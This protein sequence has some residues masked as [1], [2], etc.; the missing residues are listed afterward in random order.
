MLNG[1]ALGSLNDGCLTRWHEVASRDPPPTQLATEYKTRQLISRQQQ[2][3]E[4]GL[5]RR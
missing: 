2:L 3:D 1:T 5:I 4:M